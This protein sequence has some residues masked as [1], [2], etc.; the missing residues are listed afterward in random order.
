MKKCN[1]AN[2]KS[3]KQTRRKEGCPNTHGIICGTS[4]IIYM[5]VILHTYIIGEEKEF[6]LLDA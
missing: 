2:I 4:P 6:P 5:Y 1:K 3:N